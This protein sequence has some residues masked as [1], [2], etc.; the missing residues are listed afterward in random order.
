[1]ATPSARP[2]FAHRRLSRLVEV[3][4]ERVDLDLEGV[5]VLTEA[6]TGAYVVTPVIAALAGGDV[7]AMTTQTRYGTVE[8]VREETMRLAELLGVADRI[9]IVSDRSVDYFAQADLVTNSGHVRPITGAHADAI[10][11]GSALSLMFETWEIQAGRIDLDLDGL[12]GR[13]VRIAGTNE[14]HPHVD[15]FSYLGPMAVAELCDAGVPAYRSRVGVLCDNAFRDYIVGGLAAAGAEVRAG[16]VLSDIDLSGLD[17]LLVAMTP[18]GRSV[19]SDEDAAAL[20]AVGGDTIVVQYWGDIDREVLSAHSLAAWPPI[21][22]GNGHMAVL[23]SHVGPDAIVRLQAGGLKVGELLLK[24]PR[25][26][27]EEERAYIDE[28]P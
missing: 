7:V 26:I 6:A 20:R 9:R 24:E 3:A 25:S 19:L 22:P 10:R 13:G 2:G 1:M 23:P 5:R 15:V 18:T 16:A 28:L 27:T 21:P 14:R 4:V 8:H 11:P 12:R 17:A